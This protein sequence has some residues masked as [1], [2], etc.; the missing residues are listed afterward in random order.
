MIDIQITQANTR[1]DTYYLV[2]GQHLAFDQPLIELDAFQINGQA[3]LEPCLLPE[4]IGQSN[5]A[6]LI[7]EGQGWLGNQWRSVSNWHNDNGFCLDVAAIGRLWV[8]TD[9]SAIRLLSQETTNAAWLAE[10]LL[11]PAL[12]LALALQGTFCLHAGAV[13]MGDRVVAFVGESGRGKSTLAAYLGRQEVGSLKG[14]TSFRPVSDDVLPIS[15]HSQGVHGLPH[16]PQLKLPPDQ[17]PSLG[18]PQRLPLTAVYLLE[19]PTNNSEIAIQPLAPHEAILALVRHTV[20][21]KLFD[22][23]LLM[24]HLVFATAVAEQVPVKR[25]VYPRRWDVLTAV[26]KTIIS[27]LHP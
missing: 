27:D 14:A 4:K 22:K 3:S 1:P 23:A 11:G 8:S 5:N 18:L 16:F 20:A 17:Q 2:T 7:Y 12:T 15:L 9:G 13:A 25:L 26:G 19:Q 24:Q 10:T 6:M 21:T